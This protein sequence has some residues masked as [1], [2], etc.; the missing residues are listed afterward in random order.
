M[1]NMH[2]GLDVLL[3]TKE[4]GNEDISKCHILKGSALML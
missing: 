3:T 4:I 2:K 1:L